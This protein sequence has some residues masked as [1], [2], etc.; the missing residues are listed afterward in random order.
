M[1]PYPTVMGFR[2]IFV[3]VFAKIYMGGFKIWKRRKKIFLSDG[4]EPIGW[5]DT[6]LLRC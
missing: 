1:L 3:S 2:L 4:K 5:R 6:G